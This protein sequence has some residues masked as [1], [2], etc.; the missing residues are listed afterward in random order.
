MEI[1]LLRRNEI[2]DEK[3]NKSI[4]TSIH[5]SVYALTW[6]LDAMTDSKWQ[7]WISGDYEIVMPFYKKYKYGIPYITQPFLCQR[8]GLFHNKKEIT[9]N[10][11]DA[12][13][14]KLS[15]KVFKYDILTNDDFPFRLKHVKK[16]NQI[17]D[18][19]L[20]YE[21]LVKNYNRNTKRNLTFAKAVENHHVNEN[22]DIKAQI[23]FLKDNDPT[24]LLKKH[25]SKV[26]IL[27]K[28]SISL[29]SGFLVSVVEN[30]EIRASAFF[31]LYEKRVYFLLC[32]SDHRGKQIKSMYLLIDHVIQKYA[33]ENKIF[34]F[35]GSNIQSIAQ[36]NLGFGASVENYY[37]VKGS[38][39]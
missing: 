21:N 8:L 18:L 7:A 33:G 6:Y 16:E 13:Y 12:F 10:E 22:K 20:T 2:D 1:R 39:F 24:L 11:I 35:T 37:H 32:A 36:R 27:I 15:S 26:E 3:W 30:D 38:W 23:D 9:P 4:A 25:Y 5:V 19:T 14:D 17:L 29:K 31:I 28:S 34:D